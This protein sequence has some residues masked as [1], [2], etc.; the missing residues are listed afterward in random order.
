MISKQ[1][2]EQM[3]TGH[4]GILSVNHTQS[5]NICIM[6]VC[7]ELTELRLPEGVW[8]GA[9]GFENTLIV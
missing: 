4:T 5:K 8:L 3:D 7:S 9:N 1:I 2:Y 6:F